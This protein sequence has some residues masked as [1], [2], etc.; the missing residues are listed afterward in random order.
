MKW[1]L[2]IYIGSSQLYVP[3]AAYDTE[4]ECYAAMDEWTFEKGS[5]GVCM[6]GIMEEEPKRRR[7]R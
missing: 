6:P 4:R 3:F 7:R 2:I 5:H 1:V